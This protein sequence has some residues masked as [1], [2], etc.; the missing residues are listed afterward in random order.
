M[1]KVW[2]IHFNHQEVFKFPKEKGTPK[3]AS[4]FGVNDEI[5]EPSDQVAIKYSNHKDH[6]AESTI[7]RNKK[8]EDMVDI[9][10]IE[11][12]W[13]GIQEVPVKTQ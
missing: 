2:N 4:E 7:W 9:P 6:P 3:L 12:S 10:E 11:E 5:C 1:P 8:D 13:R